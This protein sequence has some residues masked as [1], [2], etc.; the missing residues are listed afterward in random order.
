MNIVWD[1]ITEKIKL[2]NKILL[3]KCKKKNKTTTNNM[4]FL[5][6]L[7]FYLIVWEY[8]WSWEN[9]MF[10]RN[11]Y[12]PFTRIITP[13]FAGFADNRMCTQ[14]T[15]V[16][17]LYLALPRPN[18]LHEY[19]YCLPHTTYTQLGLWI[20]ELEWKRLRCMKKLVSG[21]ALVLM[22]F[23]VVHSQSLIQELQSHTIGQ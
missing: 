21:F 19:S 13:L 14:T 3:Y 20:K 11:F 12:S 6:I 9:R 4:Y 5:C 1:N 7:P 2:N 10:G 18:Y 17:T 8:K 22:L 15:L 16:Y 23:F